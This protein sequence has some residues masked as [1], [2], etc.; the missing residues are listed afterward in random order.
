MKL[1]DDITTKA[2]EENADLM[3]RN[4]TKIAQLYFTHK[5][6]TVKHKR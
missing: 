2:K 1:V 6:I 5:L 4:S 3:I